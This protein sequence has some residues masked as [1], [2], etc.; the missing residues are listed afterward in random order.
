MLQL[1]NTS[2]R[3]VLALPANSGGELWDGVESHGPRNQLTQDHLSDQLGPPGEY[4]AAQERD[5]ERLVR[6]AGV[7]GRMRVRKV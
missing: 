7:W 5:R 6:R 4:E 3:H 1:F 2:R